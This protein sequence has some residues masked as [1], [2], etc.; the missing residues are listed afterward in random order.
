MQ[1]RQKRNQWTWRLVYRISL[2]WYGKGEKNHENK[3]N[4]D[5]NTQENSDQSDLNQNSEESDSSNNN[6]SQQESKTDNSNTENKEQ[7]S[8]TNQNETQKQEDNPSQDLSNFSMQE[9]QNQPIDQSSQ[10][11]FNRLK[12]DPSRLLKYRLYNQNRRN[13]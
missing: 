9:N 10:E 7:E 5:D 13:K 12:K 8:Q 11:I 1:Q 4:S 2:N 3:N 6:E